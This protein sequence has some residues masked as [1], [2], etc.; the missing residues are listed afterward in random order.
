MRFSAI[1]KAKVRLAE[2]A[3][4]EHSTN[5]FCIVKIAFRKICLLD[6]CKAQAGAP[7]TRA[8]KSDSLEFRTMKLASHFVGNR[9]YFSDRGH[10]VRELAPLKFVDCALTKKN[11]VPR[12][13]V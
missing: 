3:I 5:A 2:Q 8:F 6:D 1:G 12:K 9:G 10:V 13:S 4:V 11:D 7:K